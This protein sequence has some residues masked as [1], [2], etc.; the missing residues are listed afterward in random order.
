MLE[1]GDRG[2]Y[3]RKMQQWLGTCGMALEIDGQ[4]GRRT[5][6]AVK[7]FQDLTWLPTDCIYDSLVTAPQLAAC[8]G[9]PH[10]QGWLTRHS[11]SSDGRP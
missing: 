6:R 9:D 11:P 4:F 3:V 1:R 8:R 7:V 2:K 10:R 5:E